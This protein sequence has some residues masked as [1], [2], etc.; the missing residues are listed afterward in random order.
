MYFIIC[1]LCIY[2]IKKNSYGGNK[3]NSIWF[4]FIICVNKSFAN[5]GKIAKITITV[6]RAILIFLT[7]YFFIN[8]WFVMQYIYW[9][10]YC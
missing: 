2:V 5:W 8:F 10:T 9:F 1:I 7:Q 3:K 6:K 4:N